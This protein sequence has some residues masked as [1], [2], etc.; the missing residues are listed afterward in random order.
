[1]SVNIRNV[2][3]LEEDVRVVLANGNELSG[4]VRGKALDYSGMALLGIY[5]GET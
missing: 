4:S 1:M 5:P 3:G 2:F